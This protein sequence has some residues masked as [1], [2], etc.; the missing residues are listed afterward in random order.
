M[1]TASGGVF[2]LNIPETQEVVKAVEALCSG[3][4]EQAD[5]LILGRDAVSI[6]IRAAKEG[7]LNVT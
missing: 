1:K 7:L 6:L 3:S 5:R 2:I 4:P